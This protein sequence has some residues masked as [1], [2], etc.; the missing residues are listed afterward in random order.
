MAKRLGELIKSLKA[1]IKKLQ[2]SDEKT[3]KRWLFGTSTISVFL[4][5]ILW[6]LYASLTMPAITGVPEERVQAQETSR[7]ENFFTIF[8][9]GLVK[10]RSD[11]K[12]GYGGAK[13][14]TLSI[15]ENIKNYIFQTR[16]IIIDPGDDI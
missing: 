4:I 12:T 13:E 15:S 3:K 2:R 10:I 14:T 7:G 6:I 16:E 9:R 1:F 5:I 11:I 8:R